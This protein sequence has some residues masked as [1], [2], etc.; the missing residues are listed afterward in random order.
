LESSASAGLRE[1]LLQV[2]H[3]TDARHPCTDR[4]DRRRLWHLLDNR[5]PDDLEDRVTRGR[6]WGLRDNRGPAS[7]G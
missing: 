6:F 7:P 2:S 3:C 1:G 4:R 5:D